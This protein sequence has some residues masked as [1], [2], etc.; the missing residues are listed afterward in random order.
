MNLVQWFVYFWANTVLFKVPVFYQQELD[1]EK[2]FKLVMDY[3]GSIAVNNQRAWSTIGKVLGP[4]DRKAS[5]L[6]F[7]IKRLYCT[8]LLDYEKEVSPYTALDSVPM[9]YSSRKRP[10]LDDEDSDIILLDDEAI[11]LQRKNRPKRNNGSMSFENG[12]DDPGIELVG[13]D[14]MLWNDTRNKLVRASV[15]GYDP[16]TEL[17]G[18]NYHGEEL[19]EFVDLRFRTWQPAED[20]EA[21][22]Q[23]IGV[24][25]MNPSE[26]TAIEQLA[27]L[28]EGPV[29]QYYLPWGV[30]GVDQY[31][32]SNRSSVQEK[33]KAE[34]S[35]SGQLYQ[36]LRQAKEQIQSL[37]NEAAAHRLAVQ[38][39][40]RTTMLQE[41]QLERQIHDQKRRLILAR[42]HRDTLIKTQQ[43]LLKAIEQLKSGSRQN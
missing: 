25:N 36:Q 22:E 19:S 8:Y 15:N 2:L 41:N 21:G 14:I 38:D 10:K 26:T 18:I 37:E 42:N 6:A 1:V 27:R 5:S 43:D 11:Q 3:G 28:K 30:N 20:G 31:I 39:A 13:Q 7:Q 16:D 23:L 35:T 40:Y 9:V 4:R 29:T 12:E 24:H 17:H 33:T 34:H 32:N